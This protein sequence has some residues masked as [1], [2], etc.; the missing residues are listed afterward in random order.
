[1]TLKRASAFT[2]RLAEL[3]PLEPRPKKQQRKPKRRSSRPRR[4]RRY[5]CCLLL[6][7]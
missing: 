3:S 6:G 5:C 7:R 4:R 1:M 2:R